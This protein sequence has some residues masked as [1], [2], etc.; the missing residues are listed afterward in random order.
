MSKKSCGILPFR[1]RDGRLEV[2]LVHPGGPFWAGKDDAAWSISKGLAEGVKACWRQQR[3][4]LEKRRA[5]IL[6]GSS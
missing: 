6:R 3:G 2:M 1:F 5:L 4:S